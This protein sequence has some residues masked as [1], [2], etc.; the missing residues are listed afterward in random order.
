MKKQHHGK[1][2]LNR[3]SI[4]ILDGNVLSRVAGGMIK[5]T[6]ASACNGDCVPPSGDTGCHPTLYTDAC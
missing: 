3:Q 1:L 2:T 5:Q 6:G 4:R